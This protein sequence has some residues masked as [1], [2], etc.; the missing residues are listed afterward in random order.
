MTSTRGIPMRISNVQHQLHFG[1]NEAGPCNPRCRPPSIH[2]FH[3]ATPLIFIRHLICAPSCST[4]GRHIVDQSADGC[5]PAALTR[6]HRRVSCSFYRVGLL[7][8]GKKP[9][10]FESGLSLRTPRSNVRVRPPVLSPFSYYYPN[11]P[12]SARTL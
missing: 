12:P 3:H 1:K 6:S 4:A 5:G 9:T 7:A 2:P 10:F 11:C 8:Y